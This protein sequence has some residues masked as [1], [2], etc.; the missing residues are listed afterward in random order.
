MYSA[1]Y[2]I[3]CQESFMTQK[4]RINSGSLCPWVSCGTDLCCSCRVCTSL[5]TL[6]SDV[7]NQ[8][9]TQTTAYLNWNKTEKLNQGTL[10][11][12]FKQPVKQ[13]GCALSALLA[14]LAVLH[15]GLEDVPHFPGLALN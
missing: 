8:S 15:H 13:A 9:V 6:F 10:L 14:E 11:T 5:H 4:D 7:Q 12:Q 3:T 2:S 1:S